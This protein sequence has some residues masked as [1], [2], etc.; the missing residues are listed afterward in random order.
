MLS[1]ETVDSIFVIQATGKN[2]CPFIRHVF[3]IL[4]LE[5]F[6]EIIYQPMCAAVVG[7]WSSYVVSV[8]IGKLSPRFRTC[9]H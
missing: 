8:A 1:R 3:G 9:F 4:A 6:E 5:P 7:W 2:A